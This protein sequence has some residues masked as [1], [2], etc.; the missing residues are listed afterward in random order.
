MGVFS[1]GKKV[2]GSLFNK[3]ATL[4]Y[5]VIPREWEERTRGAVDIDKEKCVLCGM[6]ARSCPTGAIDVNRK[7][8]TWMIQRMNCIQC[9]ACIE[10][11]P[12]SCLIMSQKYTEPGTEKV[13][14]SFSL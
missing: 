9:G 14:D 4:M 6:C 2:I 12:P 7:T 5:P 11:C 8:S 1:I 3:P 13:V 10:N